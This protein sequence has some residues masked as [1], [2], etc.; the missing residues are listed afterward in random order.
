MKKRLA[1]LFM[2]TLAALAP[3][4]AQQGG[5]AGQAPPASPVQEE[6]QVD[7]L[8]GPVDLGLTDPSLVG[9]IDVHQHLDPDAPGVR[10]QVRALDAFDAA[11]M[12]KQRGMRGI[13]F[14]THQSPASAGVA[15]LVRRHGAA[16]VEMFGRMALNFSTGG[17]NVA[18]VE[19]FAQTKGGWGRIV[20]MPTRDAVTGARNMDREF[21]A[22]NRPWMLLMPPGAPTYVATSKDGQLTPETKHLIA[23]MAKMRTVDSNGR[24]V[25]ATGHATPDEH[26]LLTAEARRQGLQ[27]LLTHPGDIP[28]LAEATRLGAF[29][30]VNASGI[31]RT[32]AGATNAAALVRKI[33]AEH[34]IVGTDCGQM[35]NLYPTDCLALAARALRAR[36]ITQ[37]ELDLMYKANPAKLLGLPPLD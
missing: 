21:L 6:W 27:V 24:L 5:G 20:E 14:K 17:I 25:L 3:P 15:Y 9:A 33:G 13:V 19:H 31:Y 29:V 37:R 7:P 32:A 23:V 10:G 4:S 34:A 22:G 36:G 12:A 11:M 16:G 28:Q 1:A 30:E 26:L 35:T 2:L 8:R 18:A